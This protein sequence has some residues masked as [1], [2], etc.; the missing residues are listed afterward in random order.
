[1]QKDAIT[2]RSTNVGSTQ[3]NTMRI[4]STYFIIAVTLLASTAAHAAGKG[5][6]NDIWLQIIRLIAP[7]I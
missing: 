6:G 5:G 2:V 3:E 1:M 7:G 4:Y